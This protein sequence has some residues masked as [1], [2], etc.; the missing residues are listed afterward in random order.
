MVK[1][2]VGGKP[3]ELI[4][5]S[6]AEQ[7]RKEMGLEESDIQA[8]IERN[9]EAILESEEHEPVVIMG[10]VTVVFHK[11]G[12]QLTIRVIYGANEVL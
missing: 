4:M 11:A 2:S 5:E 8:V 10:D 9:P 6:D 1:L 12:N 3:F 7:K